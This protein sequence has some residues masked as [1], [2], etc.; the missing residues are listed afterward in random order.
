MN[1]MDSSGAE[2]R[3]FQDNKVN[4]MAADAMACC[5]ARGPHYYIETCLE[6]PPL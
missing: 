3:I 5:M 2:A 6:L 4:T 1:L